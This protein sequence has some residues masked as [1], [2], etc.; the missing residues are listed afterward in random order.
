MIPAPFSSYPERDS[1]VPLSVLLFVSPGL[2][3]LDL[4]QP[5]GVLKLHP[6]TRHIT[7]HHGLECSGVRC[8]EEDMSREGATH[9]HNAEG[10]QHVGEPDQT[11]GKERENHMIMPVMNIRAPIT[12]TRMKNIF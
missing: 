12:I 6:A 11:A 1:C 8:P 3:T 10:M 7:V 9:D 2:M 4:L 5:A